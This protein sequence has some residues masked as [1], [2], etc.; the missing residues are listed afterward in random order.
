MNSELNTQ[1]HSLL[2]QLDD[3]KDNINEQQYITLVNSLKL[4]KD[5]VQEK[6][7]NKSILYSHNYNDEDEEEDY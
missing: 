5:T 6:I 3:I 2:N 1:F 7:D 4:L